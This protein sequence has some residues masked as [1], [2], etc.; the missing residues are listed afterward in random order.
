MHHF[1]RIGGVLVA[2]NVNLEALA[3]AVGTPFYIY[4]DATLRRHVRVFKEAF[5]GADALVAY[6]VKANS[7]LAVLEVMREEGAGADVVS[8]GELKR[9]IK[10]GMS[11]D[12]IVFS[13]VGKTRAEMAEA[14]DAGIFQ[15]NVESEAELDAL[16]EVALSK[17]ARAAIAFR[18][19]PD[20]AA[21]GHEKIS[22]GKAEDKFGVNWEAAHAL[23]AKAAALKGVD[24]V[25]V[26]FHIGSQI[27]D[28]APFESALVRVSEIIAALRADGRIISRLD[29]GGGLGVPYGDRPAPPEPKAY[30]ELVRRMTAPLGVKLIFEPGR[31]IAANAGILVSR[32]L[33][34]KEGAAKKFLILDAGMNDLIRPA[35]YDAFHAIEPIRERDGAAQTYDIVGPVCETSDR[36]AKARALP[37]VKAGDLVAI[38]TAGAYGASLASEYNTRPLAAEVMARG[39]QYAVIRRRPSFEEMVARESG[40]G[41]TTIQG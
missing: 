7:N 23:Y 6:S 16:N 22:T 18:I 36:F 2:E 26:D 34:V 35:L 14:L 20:V 10:A 17:S 4:S 1:N 29:V 41:W 38:M 37:P 15:F 27:S 24:P 5:E 33:Y 31:M 39:N 32:V 11:P 12:T 9:A 8:G 19:N 28:L 25:G 13:G 3:D 30:A 21:G 40:G